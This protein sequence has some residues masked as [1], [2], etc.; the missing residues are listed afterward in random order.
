MNKNPRADFLL[1][2][3][4]IFVN[5]WSPLTPIPY[6]PYL[7]GYYGK[8]E[9]AITSYTQLSVQHVSAWRPVEAHLYAWLFFWK[10]QNENPHILYFLSYIKA[11]SHCCRSI[12][13]TLVIF[14]LE[15]RCLLW[16]Y[17]SFIKCVP[18]INNPL[19][20]AIFSCSVWMISYIS[21]YYELVQGPLSLLP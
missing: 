9:P 14:S 12:S 5:S 15:T 10:K 13:F 8:S 16:F 18:F 11:C 4:G 19:W 17:C 20:K 3:P 6:L 1:L 21:S 2:C 7:P